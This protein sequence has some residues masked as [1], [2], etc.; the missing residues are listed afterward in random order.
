MGRLTLIRFIALAVTLL[1]AI[2]VGSMIRQPS[3]DV[4]FVPGER[5]CTED[6]VNALDAAKMTVLVQ[7]YSFTSPEI[8]Q[9]LVKAHTRGIKVEVMLDKRQL[10]LDKRR[11]KERDSSADVL[12]HGGVSTWIDGCHEAAHN[13]VIIIDEE[14]VIS[15]S[16][17]FSRAAEERNAE[18]LLVIRDK[19]LAARY[20][21]NWQV[22]NKHVEPYAGG[23]LNDQATCPRL[24]IAAL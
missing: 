10:I 12:A 9:A 1:S 15:G 4:C 3:W 20:L 19:A 17:N 18:N 8:A 6:V 7:A 23:A 13:K 2:G 5:R 21:A 14:I 22:H 16:F 11:H 24:S